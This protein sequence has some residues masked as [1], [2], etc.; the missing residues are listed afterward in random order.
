MAAIG[1]PIK[2]LQESQGHIVAVELRNG[3]I[4]L[5]K[6]AEAEDNC[7]AQLTMTARDGRVSHLENVYIRW[8]HVRFFWRQKC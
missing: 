3:E 7:N 8:S 2:L 1:I 5:G 4:Y 6:L